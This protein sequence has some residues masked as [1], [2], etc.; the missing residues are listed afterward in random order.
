[1]EL[2]NNVYEQGYNLKLVK[3]VFSMTIKDVL[4]VDSIQ[5]LQKQTSYQSAKYTF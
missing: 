4:N 5:V 1:M 3:K 2:L